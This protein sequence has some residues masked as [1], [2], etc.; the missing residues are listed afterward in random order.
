ML[1]RRTEVGQAGL[2]IKRRQAPTVDCEVDHKLPPWSCSVK[3]CVNRITLFPGPLPARIVEAPQTGAMLRLR[4]RLCCWDVKAGRAYNGNNPGIRRKG[5]G[6]LRML[7]LGQ[8][9]YISGETG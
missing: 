5:G 4:C 9:D 8:P 2:R 6:E 3:C 7:G 1:S